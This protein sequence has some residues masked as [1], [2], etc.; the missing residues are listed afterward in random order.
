MQENRDIAAVRSRARPPDTT[1]DLVAGRR[2]DVFPGGSAAVAVLVV[3]VLLAVVTASAILGVFVVVVSVLGA[4]IG[5]C[6]AL[7]GLCNLV[8]AGR[9]AV[10]ELRKTELEVEAAQAA[11]RNGRSAEIDSSST[12]TR[13]DDTSQC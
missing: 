3:L 11:R 4:V 5:L 6:T 9:I 8:I 10:L 1:W 7:V 13:G 12:D 2:L